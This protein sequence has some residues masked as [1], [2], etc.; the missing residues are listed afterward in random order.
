MPEVADS[1]VVGWRIN[2][3]GGV[4][5]ETEHRACAGPVVSLE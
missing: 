3:E 2:T 1:D 4:V 5:E